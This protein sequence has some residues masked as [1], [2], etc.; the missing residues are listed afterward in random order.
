METHVIA[1]GY[2]PAGTGKTHMAVSKGCDMLE[3]GEVEKLV[4][5]RPVVAAAGEQLG[6]LPGDLKE[7]LNPYMLPLYDILASRIGI[8]ELRRLINLEVIELCPLAF[9]RGRTF[10]NAAIILDEM[11]NAT[12]MQF[13]MA[14]TRIGENAKCFITGDPD[15]VDPLPLGAVSGLLPTINKLRDAPGVDIVAF[16]ASGVVRSEIVSTVL[17]RL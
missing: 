11:Q 7:K 5:S 16:D 4:L 2:G 14:L 13:K 3:K 6:F 1:F 10:N 8:G 17:S 9:M 12:E 15:Q